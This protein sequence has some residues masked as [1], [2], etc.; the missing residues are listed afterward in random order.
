MFLAMCTIFGVWFAYDGWI[1]Y[2]RKNLA[3]FA[4]AL[5]SPASTDT[6]RTNP[7]VTSATL[8]AIRERLDDAGTKPIPRSELDEILGEPSYEDPSSGHAYYIGPAILAEI[9]VKN[10]QI[11]FKSD[12]RIPEKGNRPAHSERDINGQKTLVYILVILVVIALI[13]LVRILR[14]RV[15]LDDEGLTYDGKRIPWDAM[16]ALHSDR[17]RQ[18]GWVDL[19]YGGEGGGSALRI[20]NYKVKAFKEIVSAICEKKGFPNPIPP[21]TRTAAPDD[22][23]E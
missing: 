9:A 5:P 8:A 18:K 11:R 10:E 7:R 15:V 19:E 17:Y 16:T 6:L 1:G 4:Q 14:T 22:S 12:I 21:A 20:D 13:Q 2:P 23:A 3:Y